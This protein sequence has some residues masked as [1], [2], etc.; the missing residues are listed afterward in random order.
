MLIEPFTN[1]NVSK[2]LWEVVSLGAQAEVV[3]N[4][5]LHGVQIGVFHLNLLSKRVFDF[6]LLLLKQ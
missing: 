6:I 1:L 3:E 5:F 4:V 2:H